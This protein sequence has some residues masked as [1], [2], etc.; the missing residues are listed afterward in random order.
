MKKY[1]IQDT[2]TNKET[3]EVQ[4]YFTGRNGYVH[5]EDSFY[6][7][8]G[9]TRRCYA[10]KKIA[11]EIKWFSGIHGQAIDDMHCIEGDKWY[12]EYKIL[13][14]ECGEMEQYEKI[15]IISNNYRNQD[16]KNLK[17]L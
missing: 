10:E 14:I 3:N 12:H 9:Y 17:S 15:W 11:H 13:E 4:I 8:D 6:W 7:C 16:R 1:I 2:I 5:D